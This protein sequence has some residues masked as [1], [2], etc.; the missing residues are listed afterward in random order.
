MN[1]GRL[2]LGSIV[3]ALGV[4]FI[5]G[6]AD[7]LDASDA[8]ADWW[9]LA[10][11]ALG[12]FHTAATRSW[13]GGG[14]VIT[15]VGLALLG[16]TTG[17]F[18]SNAW[19]YVWPSALV[20]VGLWIMVGWGRRWGAE[21]TDADEIDG[22]AVLGSA[23]FAT[24]SQQFRRASLTS[25]LGGV[26]LDLTEALPIAAGGS[27]SVTAILGG[28]TLLVPRGW[29]VEVRGIPLMGGWDDT[30]DRTAVGSGAPRLE[31]Q[32]L[33]AL[34]GVEVKHSGRWH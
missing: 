28:A 22:L 33:V 27:I 19:D 25:L 20:L 7:V 5:L 23:R 11:V 2:L 3:A 31:V 32:A 15:L 24:R 26:T 34:G 12:L 21:P 8:L 17:L 1:A 9:P 18:G 6:S 29:L 13:R 10:V 30:T 14:G 4:V 16:V